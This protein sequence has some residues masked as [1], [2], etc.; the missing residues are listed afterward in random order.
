MILENTTKPDVATNQYYLEHTDLP[1]NATL[2][3]Q[4]RLLSIMGLAYQYS[5]FQDRHWRLFLQKSIS[6]GSIDAINYIFKIHST[7]TLK[8]Q[9][10][11]WLAAVGG[12]VKMIQY[13]MVDLKQQPSFDHQI[14]TSVIRFDDLE[15]FKLLL[16]IGSSINVHFGETGIGNAITIGASKIVNFILDNWSDFRIVNN[17]IVDSIPPTILSVELLEKLL[18]NPRI[19]CRFHHVLATAIQS[20]NHLV[21]NYLV[22]LTNFPKLAMNYNEA[23]MHAVLKSDLQLVKK[24]VDNRKGY[25]FF[26][27][28]LNK[29]TNLSP[30]FYLEFVKLLIGSR[31]Q[32]ALDQRT[33]SSFFNQI[34]PGDHGDN[35][36]QVLSVYHQVLQLLI[37]H[38]ILTSA[39]PLLLFAALRENIPLETIQLLLNIPDRNQSTNALVYI[40][41]DI[42]ILQYIHEMRPAVLNINALSLKAAFDFRQ[43]EL[44]DYLFDTFADIPLHANANQIIGSALENN[45]IETIKAYFKR[46][47]INKS[48]KLINIHR[49]SYKPEI[50]DYI[51]T[52]GRLAFSGAEFLSNQITFRDGNIQ[53]FKL[54]IEHLKRNKSGKLEELQPFLK[55]A[56][57]NNYQ[58][59]VEC[60][61]NQL[62]PTIA[63]PAIF[64][65]SILFGNINIIKYFSTRLPKQIN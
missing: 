2:E 4:D 39:K 55:A 20:D 33:I 38:G 42:K 35:D 15:C 52:S 8:L 29:T 1:Q 56:Q 26:L 60:Y 43:P 3:N 34:Y 30:D 47:T 16:Q 41:R 63:I 58:Q 17:I 32:I 51:L 59:L 7:S 57:L 50:M 45:N 12:G 65:Q 13:L 37:D 14:F 48:I 5:L 6:I 24:I 36:K 22:Q 10:L 61:E 53:T 19:V 54:V 64:T 44:I 49:H 28:V 9:S 27:P 46:L 21:T 18:A 40:C 23:L 25:I 62:I 31:C 11:D